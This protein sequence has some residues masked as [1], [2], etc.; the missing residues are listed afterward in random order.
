VNDGGVGAGQRL[1]ESAL[2]VV[3]R[4]PGRPGKA[5][6]GADRGDDRQPSAAESVQGGAQDPPA[7]GLGAQALHHLRFG[8]GGQAPEHRI[9][10]RLNH[11]VE[12]AQGLPRRAQRGLGG[13]GIGDVGDEALGAHTL[14]PE[15][16]E[17]G[18]ARV[19]HRGAAD[20]HQVGRPARRHARRQRPADPPEAADDGHA[21]G[22]GR[23]RR[24]VDIVQP[25]LEPAAVAQADEIAGRRSRI[26]QGGTDRHP[27]RDI[28][29]PN[30]RPLDL[31]ADRHLGEGRE[32][33]A[34]RILGAVIAQHQ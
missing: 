6:E 5:G 16:V 12:T 18:R 13:G 4:L 32:G 29:Q 11:Q 27:I 10:H 26:G 15:R 33:A 8:H 23:R 7:L 31:A 14:G 24:R 21:P 25:E 30:L 9:D 19:L 28:D 34:H 1:L 3:D 22:R 20:Q 17:E 2:C